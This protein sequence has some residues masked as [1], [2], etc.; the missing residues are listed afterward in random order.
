MDPWNNDSKAKVLRGASWYNGALK[1]SLLFL[2]RVHASA[3]SRYGQLWFPA[4]A[5]IRFPANPGGVIPRH[6]R[7]MA[8]FGHCHCPCFQKISRPNT[9]PTLI[10]MKKIPCPNSLSFLPRF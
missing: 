9:Y 5:R 8:F 7:A 4:R 1:L 6:L 3:D 10:A 2:C